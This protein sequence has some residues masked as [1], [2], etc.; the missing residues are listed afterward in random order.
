MKLKTEVMSQVY[1]PLTVIIYVQPDLST[2]SLNF[3]YIFL[4]ILRRCKF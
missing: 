2:C 4:S 3:F 1:I